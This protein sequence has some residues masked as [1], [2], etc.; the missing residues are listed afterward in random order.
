MKLLG[1]G[2]T[3]WKASSKRLGPVVG[4]VFAGIVV[5]GYLFLDRWFDNE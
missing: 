2:W 3:V 1:I 5:A 4:L